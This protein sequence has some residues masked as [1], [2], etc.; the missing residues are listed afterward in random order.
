MTRHIN[1]NA[2]AM[3][4]GLFALLVSGCGTPVPRKS[5]LG[6][7]LVV[8]GSGSAYPMLTT[9]TTAFNQEY[10]RVQIS[11]QPSSQSSTAV[12]Y[13]AEGKINIGAIARALTN[14]E[15]TADITHI[16]IARDGIVV[17]VHHN[18]SVTSLTSAQIRSI[19][20]GSVHSW[21]ELGG[22]T[23]E[24]IVLD[25]AESETAKIAL[26][27]FVI[28]Q[29]TRIVSDATILPTEQEMYESVATVAD[30]IGY[31]S[32]SY[33]LKNPSKVRA[34][35]ID[36]V[37]PSLDTMQSGDYAVVRPVG[38]VVKTDQMN[39]SPLKEFLQFLSSAQAQSALTRDG[40]LPEV[41]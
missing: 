11:F 14:Q 20:T 10:P 15:R 16:P 2:W 24:I 5:D 18:V 25:R 39:V 38:I 4:A 36:G 17:A 6:G 30:T 22:E 35:T 41:R 12:K 37:T 21:S 40:F 7:T 32:F 29:N 13:V 28:G 33:V 27:Q 23:R 9:L 31:F 34:L 19:Y 8:G 1:L 26:R 3:I